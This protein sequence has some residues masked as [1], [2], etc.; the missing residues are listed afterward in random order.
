MVTLVL[1][2]LLLG[3]GGRPEMSLVDPATYI[4]HNCAQLDR[5]M[6]QFREREQELRALYERAVKDAPLIAAAAY[7]A[8]YLSTI[9]N[10]QLIETAAQDRECNAPATPA[11]AMP[12]R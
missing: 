7:E 11:V 1:A 10:M 9:G 6:R 4:F 3:C 2:A 12:A 5:D 8:D